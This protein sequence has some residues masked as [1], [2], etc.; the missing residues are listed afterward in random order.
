MAW[1]VSV[2]LP[3]GA[4]STRCRAAVSQT[5][6]RVAGKNVSTSQLL[7]IDAHDRFQS[8]LEDQ[9]LL[10]SAAMTCREWRSN[11]LGTEGNLTLAD[12]IDVLS[13]WNN[14]VIGESGGGMMTDAPLAPPRHSVP[15]QMP[16]VSL[17]WSS[18]C[19]GFAG[20]FDE[21]E[22]SGLLS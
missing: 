14:P 16:L 3:D 11:L 20:Q 17:Q 12:L 2:H 1:S 18:R 15:K 7:G 21:P 5:G 6:T 22:S 4:L 10:A 19:E 13:V 9:I 8:G